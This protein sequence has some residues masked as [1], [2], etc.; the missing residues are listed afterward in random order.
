MYC[1]IDTQSLLLHVLVSSLHEHSSTL[2]TVFHVNT[3]TL[4]TVVS[5]TCNIVTQILIHMTLLFHVHELLI[6]GYSTALFHVLVSSLHEHS[7]TL[8]TII[9]CTVTLLHYH[10]SDTYYYQHYMD[11]SGHGT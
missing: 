4:D 1:I 10:Y 2:D 7:C 5:S 6:H 3:L 9:S 8:D 11:T